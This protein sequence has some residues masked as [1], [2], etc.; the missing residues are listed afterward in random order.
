MLHR[1]VPLPLPK[2]ASPTPRHLIISFLLL[3][4]SFSTITILA[5]KTANNSISSHLVNIDSN[6]N[7][8]NNNNSSK[9]DKNNHNTCSRA[10]SRINYRYDSYYED[11]RILTANTTGIVI[12][13]F[14]NNHAHNKQTN[15]SRSSEEEKEERVDLKDNEN[16][17]LP[18]FNLSLVGRGSEK[19]FDDSSGSDG[20]SSSNGGA[21]SDGSIR[22]KKKKSSTEEVYSTY[23]TLLIAS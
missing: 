1:L 2:T 3:Y 7:S 14:L 9:I 4:T 17:T 8:S 21:C 20:C 10:S 15:G 6:S 23:P 11:E 12:A 19:F 5:H 18:T 22:K 16:I 13:A